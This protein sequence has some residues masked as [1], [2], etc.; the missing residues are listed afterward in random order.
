M[1]IFQV[2]SGLSPQRQFLA[3]MSALVLMAMLFV[4]VRF[5]LKPQTDLLY[6]GLDPSVAG[7]VVAKLETLD[8]VYEVR[9]NAIYTDRA[10]RDAL[11]LEL[12]KDG[13]P[14]QSIQGYELLDELNSFAMTSEMFDTAYWRAKEGELART[15]L[16]MP[17]V[18]TA[19]VHFGTLKASGFSKNAQANSASVTVATSGGLSHSQAKAIQYMTA[20]AVQ[21]LNPDEVAVID[22]VQGVVAGPGIDDPAQGTGTAQVEL[23]ERLRSEITSLL[24]ARVGRGNARV[25]VALDISREH[26]RMSEN[27]YDPEGSVLKSKTS[28]EVSDTSSGTQASVSVASNLPEGDAGASGESTAESSQTTESLSYEISSTVRETEVLPGSVTRISIAVLLSDIVTRDGETLTRTP[29]EPNELEELHELVSAA[30]GLNEKR[31]DKLTLK[32]LAFDEPA[33][34]AALEQPGVFAQFLDRY[35]WSLVQA[36]ILAVVVIALGVFVLRPLLKPREFD[37]QME[38]AL[39]PMSLDRHGDMDG[40]PASAAPDGAPLLSGRSGEEPTVSRSPLEDLKH[41]VSA[42]PGDAAELLT[43]WLDTAQAQT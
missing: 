31:G 24:E 23:Q 22:T 28:E 40:S 38:A 35:L 16:A 15:M 39:L 36:L 41:S 34:L 37:P 13:L 6:A 32:S 20:L 33:Q 8:V 25:N 18:R 5:A 11:R 29:R 10:R 4:L 30:A 42:H 7:E 12:A 43:S 17:S 14:R 2:W 1:G 27:R 26:L 21:G 19:R 9:G 3:A